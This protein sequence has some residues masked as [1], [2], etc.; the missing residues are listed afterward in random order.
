MRACPPYLRTHA[1]TAGT[2]GGNVRVERITVLPVAPGT[3]LAADSDLTITVAWFCGTAWQTEF[4]DVFAS[5]GFNTADLVSASSIVWTPL[6]TRVACTAAGSQ[7]TTFTGR[8]AASS[9]RLRYLIRAVAANWGNATV[10][11]N[12]AAKPCPSQAGG[13]SLVAEQSR[14]V[15]D[16]LIT[17][18]P[19]GEGVWGWRA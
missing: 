18:E 14:D 11:A 3:V 2:Y 15:D 10:A 12:T 13:A 7:S 5:Q 19:S 1:G 6:K 4:L 17:M 8:L 9:A 16:L